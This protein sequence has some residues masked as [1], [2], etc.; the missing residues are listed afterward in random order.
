MEGVLPGSRH[1]TP[2]IRAEALGGAVEN[3]TA[4]IHEMASS[5]LGKQLGPSVDSFNA[6]LEARRTQISSYASGAT[7]VLIP[8][9]RTFGAY[10]TVA[11]RCG[12]RSRVSSCTQTCPR[13]A[14]IAMSERCERRC[15]SRWKH[16]AT[17]SLSLLVWPQHL[18]H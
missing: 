13:L 14:S 3:A 7:A 4:L 12:T 9:P 11:E 17:L 1:F 16:R 10:Y 8:K 15:V 2:I 6:L 5:T 18:S